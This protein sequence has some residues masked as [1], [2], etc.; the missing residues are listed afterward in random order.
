MKAA[1]KAHY[2]ELCRKAEYYNKCYYNDDNPAVTDYEYDMLM[3]EIK[4][5]ETE[6]PQLVTEQSPTQHVGGTAVNTFAP[7]T[8]EVRMESLQDV[9]SEEELYDFDRRVRETDGNPVYSVEPKIDGLS[10]SL[11]Y[12]NGVFVRGSTRGDGNVGED[13]SANLLTIRS[14]PKKLAA[15][16]ARLEVRGEVYMPHSSFDKLVNAQA[17]EGGN[18]PKNP[19]NAAAGSLRQKNPRIAAD[20]ELDIFI[21]NVQQA[22]GVQFSS[23]IQSLDYLKSIGLKVLPFYKKCD[24]IEEAVEEVRRIGELRSTLDFDIDGAVIKADDLALRRKMGST[25]KYPKWAVAFKYPP[26]ERATD[27]T[28]IE[29]TVGRTGAI[30]PT[31][32][33]NPIQLAGTTVSRATLHNQDI[34]DS[35]GVNV[36]DTVVVRKAGEIIPEIIRVQAKNSDG[37]FKLPD[38]C[39]SCGSR[40]VREPDEAVL[41]CVNPECPAQLVRNLIHFASRDAMD[42][43]GLGEAMVEQLVNAGFLRSPADIYRLRAEDILSLERTGEKTAENLLSAIEKSKSNDLW[44]LIF[45]LGIHLIGAKAA[46]LLEKSFASLDEIV[47]ADC[48]RLTSI[49]GFGNIM[50]QSLTDYFSLEQSRKLV[51]ELSGLGLNTAS[52]INSEGGAFSGKTF[53]LTGTLPTM[54]RAQATEIIE[55]LGGKAS[56]SVSKKTDFLLAG[57]QAGSKLTKAEQL[58]VTVINEDEFKKMA[59]I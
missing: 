3:L 1:V 46:K 20:R 47:D 56:S 53:V 14:I 30:T 31:A 59:G 42:I 58:G 12:E 41:R 34:I 52:R 55:A 8:H 33:F 7:V 43:E 4:H 51:S 11:E 10:V 18:L 2:E 5:L 48:D 27:I 45:G 28:E 57:E 19:R 39:P 50:A 35:L 17:E 26:E 21:F 16:P 15:A 40:V 22:E 36:G 24:N 13:V 23:H 44:R 49:D 32:V 25:A 6:Y 37:A 54:S 38:K 29:V 9:F